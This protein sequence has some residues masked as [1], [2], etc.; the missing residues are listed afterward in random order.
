MTRVGWL[1]DVLRDA[2]AHVLEEGDWYGRGKA[3]P[4]APRGIMLHHDASAPGPSD[5]MVGMLIDGR[6]DLAGP[7]CHLWLDWWGTW[8]VI[9]GGRANHAGYGDGWGVAR[10]DQGNTD[11]IGIEIDH[12]TGEAWSTGQAAGGGRHLAAL[13]DALGAVPGNALCGHKEYAPGRKVDPDPLD[14]GWLR[15]VVATGGTPPREPKETDMAAPATCTDSRGRPWVLYRGTDGACWARCGGDPPFSLGG[16]VT[17]GLAVIAGPDGVL[18]VY[19]YV[20]D[21]ALYGIHSDGSGWGSWYP[22][23]R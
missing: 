15:G 18:D 9:A 10:P 1:A 23:T 7:L 4:F 22:V 14:M 19:A 20:P 5:G 13:L 21:G 17:D 2:G 8:H 16:N 12:T 3:E 11:T 6:P